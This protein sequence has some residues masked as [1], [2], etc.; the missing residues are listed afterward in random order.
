MTTPY[1][2]T[3]PL[4]ISL[5]TVDNSSAVTT[6]LDISSIHFANSLSIINGYFV[7]RYNNYLKLPNILEII[8]RF[9]GFV[10]W[11]FCGLVV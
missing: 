7:Q 2:N 11:W 4:D 3:E 10:V 8:L 5:N 9:C 1:T 6:Y